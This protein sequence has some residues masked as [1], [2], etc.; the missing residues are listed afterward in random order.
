MKNAIHTKRNSLWHKRSF[1]FEKKT[2]NFCCFWLSVI[3]AWNLVQSTKYL[4]NIYFAV[5]VLSEKCCWFAWWEKVKRQFGWKEGVLSDY[6]KCSWNI[7]AINHFNS[8][9]CQ[10]TK[11]TQSQNWTTQKRAFSFT[12]HKLHSCTWLSIHNNCAFNC[13][14]K[15]SITKCN[16]NKIIVEK[17]AFFAFSYTNIQK[18]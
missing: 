16:N 4:R 6:R 11:R 15:N 9:R 7:I 13:T 14:K 3:C 17:I 5:G 18:I 1:F 2:W 12:F 10:K 8:I